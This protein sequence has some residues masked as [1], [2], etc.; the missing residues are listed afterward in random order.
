MDAISG[1]R[2][3]AR[4]LLALLV[5]AIH[6]HAAGECVSAAPCSLAC[7]TTCPVPESAFA[8]GAAVA[9]GAAPGGGGAALYDD[10]LAP[11][12]PPAALAPGAS[13]RMD[14]LISRV[15]AV[16]EQQALATLAALPPTQ[17][18]VA[19]SA[20][21]GAW[22]T[23]TPGHWTSGFW[24]GVLWQLHALTGKEMWSAAAQRWQAALADKQRLWMA[25]HDFGFIY[26]PSFAASY[27]VTRSQSDLRQALAAAEALAWSFNP[28]TRSL[29]TFEGWAPRQ[30]TAGYKQIV[31][32][33]FMLNIQMLVWGAAHAAEWPHYA[34]LVDDNPAADWLDMAIEHARQVAAHHVRPDGSTFHIVEYQP[35]TGGVNA[36]YTYQGYAD[37]STW[38][39]GQ[40]W[41]VAGFALMHA[42]T[43][44]PEF[45]DTARRVADRWLGLLHEQGGGTAGSYVPLW[46][47]NAPYDPANDGPRDTSAA[48][49][50]ALGLLHLAEALPGSDC[51]A[52]YLCAAV[53]TLR[54]LAGPKYLAVPGEPHAALLKHAT[55][56]LPDH[57]KIDVG[58]V[59]AD[60]YYLAALRNSRAFQRP[61]RASREH[62]QALRCGTLARRHQQQQMAA[63]PSTDRRVIVYPDYINATR[64]VAQGR[65]IPADKACDTP[66][67][68]EM[69]DVCAK[70]L[71]LPAEI[72]AKRYPRNW[73][74]EMGKEVCFGRLRVQL[75]NADG[76]P[77][78]PDVPNRRELLLKLAEFCAKHPNR[79]RKPGKDAPA[80]GGGGGGGGA[81]SSK[82]SGKKSG[83][84][85]K[86]APAARGA[87]MATDAAPTAADQ[88]PESEPA[89]ATEFGRRNKHLAALIPDAL[90]SAVDAV[91][92]DSL[93]RALDRGCKSVSDKY[94][95]F[96]TDMAEGIGEVA[97][98]LLK[99]AKYA[100]EKFHIHDLVFGV[101]HL[102]LHHSTVDA[103]DGV[104]GTHV[105]D[106]ALITHLVQATDAA[107]KAY[108]PVK[109]ELC[110]ALGVGEEDVLL[111]E[112]E[113]TT[114]RPAYALWVDAK[115]K[116]LVWGFRGTTDLNDMLTD[117]CASCTPYAGGYA[118]WGMLQAAQWF[119]DNELP[120]V[121]GFLDKHPG[122]DL[123]LV[124]H[125]LGAGTA[126]MLAHLLVN[127][128]AA[129]KVMAGV[130]VTAVGVA[131]PAVL[132][133]ELA[134]GCSDYVTSVV[135]MH[136]MVPRFSI[137]NVFAM[138]E[139]MDATRWG[140]ILAATIKDWAVPDAI[141]NSET[142]K[143][144]AAG[145]A[146]Q[147]RKTQ[148]AIARGAL[149]VQSGVVAQ[150]AASVRDA[151]GA[152]AATARAAMTD[153]G[154]VADA[155][156]SVG[157]QMA[158]V[159]KDDVHAVFAPGRL[160]FIK[161]LDAHKGRAKYG[162]MEHRCALCEDDAALP[163]AAHAAEG[164]PAAGG[165]G[166]EGG[167]KAY[168]L[169]EA[170]PGQ[171]FKRIVLRETCLLDHLC[172]GYVEGLKAALDRAAAKKA[173]PG[174]SSA[175]SADRS[176]ANRGA[177]GGRSSTAAAAAA[178][179]PG[180]QQLLGRRP[181]WRRG[182]S[183][184]GM[185]GVEESP[186][187]SAQA[188]CQAVRLGWL[189]QARPCGPGCATSTEE[190]YWR[191]P[192]VCRLL[193]RIDSWGCAMV[194]TNASGML[195]RNVAGRNGAGG[196]GFMLGPMLVL[197]V[198]AVIQAQAITRYPAA[199]ARRRLLVT[200]ANRML[201]LAATA[202]PAVVRRTSVMARWVAPDR[203][204][205]GLLLAGH[206]LFPPLVQ[207]NTIAN[208][209]LP[210]RVTI[211]LQPLHVAIALSWVWGAPPAM[212]ALPGVPALATA[213]CSAVRT[214][215]A[216][217]LHVL[218][219]LAAP[220]SGRYAAAAS[221]DPCRRELVHAQLLVFSALLV[222]L[223]LPLMVTHAVELRH[224][225][226]FWRR[227]H[228]AVLLDRSL[229]LPLPSRPLAR[230][231]GPGCA[232]STE[233]TYWR[234]PEVCRLLARIDSWGCA[235][236]FI[237][238]GGMLARNVAG[239][240]VGFPRFMVWVMLVLVVIALIQAWFIAHHPAAYARRRLRVTFANRALRLAACTLPAVVRRGRTMARW[241][242][243]ERQGPGLLLA[244]H[245]LFPPLLHLNTSAN[246]LLP[247]RFV[248][249]LQP[250]HVAI[251]LS[252]VWG[253]P[254]AMAAL[255]GV[256]ALATAV[257]SAVRT[258]MAFALHVL[259][260]LAA[261]ASGRYA[262]AASPDP[263]RRELVH[264]QLLV[265]SALLV[266]LVLPLMV[267]HAV[268]LRH[269][270]AFWRRRHVAVLLDRSLLLPLPSRPL[271][272]HALVLAGGCL[273]AWCAAE[274]VAPLLAPV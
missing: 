131:T 104:E 31:I 259:F 271:V 185:S 250:L 232:T 212:A 193:A 165:E 160:F 228:V 213:V 196:P 226:A 7:E 200:F 49:V 88:A 57:D 37:N 267:T 97:S 140:D 244:G 85:K 34:N 15:T 114:T 91:L 96:K 63:Q 168:E 170:A 256:P 53:N 236:V 128:A 82:Q 136:D 42:S 189:L 129:S 73:C 22:V 205:P 230:P 258:P 105:H 127:D 100:Y 172:G 191:S 30:A 44:L 203:Q 194:F 134:E 40:S 56:N 112:P 225:Q 186:R 46:D 254:P 137:H 152:T 24:P 265:F 68:P 264:A 270:Q 29:R 59:Y 219:E 164:A 142:Y 176:A 13:L 14:A 197:V 116:A 58:L 20:A 54:A 272:S 1:R 122:Y 19:T 150:P 183:P 113:T 214:P 74:V 18:P 268:E 48:A 169:I 9:A 61:L 51:G 166:G 249:F 125:S 241:V 26:M 101:Y 145:S 144:L 132:T 274:Q 263:C 11:R 70:A 149:A 76:T 77:V 251:A 179:P 234:S 75:K 123:L 220:A 143:R 106:E 115:R 247:T 246:F 80:G 21:T 202:L 156:Q 182:R 146:V 38:A 16:A 98:V 171:R 235:M 92:P 141:E 237:N 208:F 187:G 28:A 240:G 50:A 120:Q 43:G 95:N 210:T 71:H 174:G 260:E 27:E 158:N 84:K 138:K 262:A 153:A 10:A 266:S 155:V 78:N 64:T 229:L 94:V 36:R 257:C 67:L 209:L 6:A 163:R 211:F 192:E 72:E 243:P 181:R 4:A 90:E 218:F 147:L 239:R 45:L 151:A 261:P 107:T 167:S 238:A 177:T 242:A 89:A 99:V 86:A 139:E 161:R 103:M 199:Y 201:R 108:I 17:F 119:V 148:G 66:T 216:F 110:E 2:V 25:Q 195:A 12:A 117:A 83:K 190:T 32:I 126:A 184:A 121:R 233:E 245:V 35:D 109:S 162:N 253:A 81:S 62:L 178:H 60:Y 221:P 93:E 207:L 87:A 39:R 79:H 269:K 248:V 223:V 217:A 124:G 69:L 204:G 47:F 215:M 222:S 224:K 55:G 133:R 159:A 130:K 8:L 175:A 65:R 3:A 157:Q 180:Q 231:C 41:A 252:W 206:V 198:L 188:P 227:R 33:D 23:V 173:Q 135:L 273:V 255:P 5:G 52:R 118:H 111:F 102:A 154:V